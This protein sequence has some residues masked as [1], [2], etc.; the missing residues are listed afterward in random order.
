MKVIQTPVRFYPF[1]GGVEQYVYYV[2]KELVKYD[3][4]KV[5]VIC[6]N[7]PESIPTETYQ[8]IDIKRLK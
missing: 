1:I 2:S 7:E 5:K 8:G 3:D 6:A 4:C